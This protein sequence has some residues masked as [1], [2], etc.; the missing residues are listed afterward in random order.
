VHHT[1]VGVADFITGSHEC[2]SLTSLLT[3]LGC[4]V[5]IIAVQEAIMAKFPIISYHNLTYRGGDTLVVYYGHDEEGRVLSMKKEVFENEFLETF[6]FY[7]VVPHG[8]IGVQYDPRENYLQWRF[9]ATWDSNGEVTEIP[10]K[11]VYGTPQVKHRTWPRVETPERR[12]AL[13][14]FG[15]W[16]H[17]AKP[18]YPEIISGLE[19]MQIPPTGESKEGDSY[20]EYV[21]QLLLDLQT[22]Q[23]RPVMSGL[24]VHLSRRL[25]GSDLVPYME[26]ETLEHF[27][28]RS[29]NKKRERVYWNMLLNWLEYME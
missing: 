27:K 18:S 29:E 8:N 23:A 10:A 14:Q 9:I 25:Q 3:Q 22:A 24:R 12:E 28:E 7:L 15:D 2:D 16:L 20:R 17:E 19:M 11:G 4:D 13:Q 1:P 21:R 5:L 26:G 6:D